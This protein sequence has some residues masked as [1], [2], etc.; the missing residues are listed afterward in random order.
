MQRTEQS[1]IGV[2]TDQ[3]SLHHS[4]YTAADLEEEEEDQESRE[5]ASSPADFQG[6]DRI[7]RA[8]VVAAREAQEQG[9]I[10]PDILVPQDTRGDSWTSRK[11]RQA[12]QSQVLDFVVV[13]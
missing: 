7:E 3:R 11:R 12:Q 1:E 6:G 9:G 4:W 10:V 13:W 2:Y 5:T 8:V